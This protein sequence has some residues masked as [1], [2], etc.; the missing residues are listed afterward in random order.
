MRRLTVI[1]LTWAKRHATCGLGSALSPGAPDNTPCFCL[2]SC[3]SDFAFLCC[4]FVYSCLFWYFSFFV[5]AMSAYFGL[6]EFVLIV[7]DLVM[8][9]AFSNWIS[10]SFLTVISE[11]MISEARSNWIWQSVLTVITEI[12]MNQNFFIGIGKSGVNVFVTN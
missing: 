11:I 3:Y 1:V 10:Q 8:N 4:F 6:I 12:V 9:Q 5:M 2:G 7:G